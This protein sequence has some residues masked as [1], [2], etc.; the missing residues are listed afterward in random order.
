MSNIPAIFEDRNVGL[1]SDETLW[2]NFIVSPY[3][4]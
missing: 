4:D 1:N 2:W 3:M